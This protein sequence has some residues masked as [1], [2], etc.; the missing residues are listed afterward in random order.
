[1]TDTTSALCLTMCFRLYEARTTKT[2]WTRNQHHKVAPMALR[3]SLPISKEHESWVDQAD[4][5]TTP[6]SLLRP[7]ITTI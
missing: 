5:P 2:P 6:P 7:E 3:P 4:L 1:M